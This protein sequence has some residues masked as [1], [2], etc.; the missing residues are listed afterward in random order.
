MNKSQVIL[1]L[2]NF[3]ILGCDP[4]ARSARVKPDKTINIENLDSNQS[5]PADAYFSKDKKN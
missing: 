3:F 4:A 2:V 5:V 1:I